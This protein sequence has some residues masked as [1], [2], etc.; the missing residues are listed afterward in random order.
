QHHQASALITR[1]AVKL[2]GDATKFPDQLKD[3]VRAW[4][5]RKF[6]YS[7]GFGFPGEPQPQGHVARI[8]L[9]GYDP[10]RGNTSEEIGSEGPSTQKCQGMAELLPQPGSVA[11]TYQLV[12]T[13][14]PAQQQKDEGSLFEGV[15]TTIGG[16]AKFAGAR[17][18]KDLTE[19]LNVIANAVVNAQKRFEADEVAL[20]PLLDGLFAVRVLRRELRGMAIDE[21]ARYE[22]DFRLRQKEREFQQGALLANGVKV[23]AFSDDGVVVPGQKT[24]VSVIVANHG[25]T[26]VN[27]KQIK[28]EGFDGDAACTLSAVPASSGFAAMMGRGRGEPPTPPGPAVSVIR[29][30]QVAKCD[31]TVTVPAKARVT[32]PYWHRKD[33]AGRYTFDADAPFGLPLR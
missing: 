5:P 21:A 22:I 20:K 18:P 10:L 29:R 26:D 17:P 14:L 16:L 12:E 13:T 28:F 19:G 23:E 4:Q 30:D 15:D 31:A 3:G 33:E 1:E 24:R 9:S 25:A 6:Y 32:E 7:A 27:V 2:A 8:T 11:S